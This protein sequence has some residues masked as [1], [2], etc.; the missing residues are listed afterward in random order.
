MNNVNNLNDVNNQ[1]GY[2]IGVI[3]VSV[4]LNNPCKQDDNLHS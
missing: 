2:S 4:R 3:N 1:S